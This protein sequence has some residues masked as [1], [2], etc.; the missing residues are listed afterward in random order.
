MGIWD[1]CLDTGMRDF[2]STVGLWGSHSANGD[3]GIL[4]SHREL[5]NQ[6]F[7]L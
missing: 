4:L 7:F 3:K 2:C 5:L 6:I 1:S